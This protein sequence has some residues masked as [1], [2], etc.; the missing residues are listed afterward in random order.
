MRLQQKKIHLFNLAINQSNNNSKKHKKIR[1]YNRCVMPIHL[2][3]N[4]IIFLYSQ[5][6]H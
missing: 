5:I 1:E 4:K 2:Y 3:L 6:R